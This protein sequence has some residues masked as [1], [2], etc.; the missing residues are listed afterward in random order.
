MGKDSKETKKTT[1]KVSKKDEDHELENTTQKETNET[2]I[3]EVKEK[4]IR[5]EKEKKK[6]VKEEEANEENEQPKT[7][8]DVLPDTLLEDETKNETEDVT[9]KHF[10]SHENKKIKSVADFNLDEYLTKTTT[11]KDASMSE[12]LKTCIAKSQLNGQ[13]QLY[14]TLIHTLRATNHECAFP[15][16]QST[17]SS[18]RQSKKPFYKKPDFRNNS[19]YDEQNN[20][21]YNH[22]PRDNR[23]HKQNGRYQTFDNGSKDK[24]KYVSRPNKNRFNNQEKKFDDY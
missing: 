3:D 14:R 18:M 19:Q 13:T 17:N 22:D 24:P 12:L 8:D 15:T 7:D 2:F 4:K 20:D 21:S 9:P 5:K 6:V 1:K 11:L 10:D 16:L 23:E